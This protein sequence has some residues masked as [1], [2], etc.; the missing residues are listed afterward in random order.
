MQIDYQP[1]CL[2]IF[3]LEASTVRGLCA[4]PPTALLVSG[5]KISLSLESATVVNVGSGG[6]LKFDMIVGAVNGS[7]SNLECSSIATE[8][9]RLCCWISKTLQIS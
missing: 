7:T 8:E 4:T 1:F 5:L 6:I 2:L 3:C 9:A